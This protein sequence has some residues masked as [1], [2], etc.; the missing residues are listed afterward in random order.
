MRISDRPPKQAL[1][2]REHVLEIYLKYDQSLNSTFHPHSTTQVQHL[3]GV[4]HTNFGRRWEAGAEQTTRGLHRLQYFLY[5]PRNELRAYPWP[6]PSVSCI[7]DIHA[8]N[9]VK[10]EPQDRQQPHGL[11]RGVIDVHIDP[12]NR[13]PTASPA[14]HE[15]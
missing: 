2:R 13:P 8:S 15:L 7:H 11:S 5:R 1:R 12:F 14:Q 4:R 6:C 9:A 3:I 10:Q